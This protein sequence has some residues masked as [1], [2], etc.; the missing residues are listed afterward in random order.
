MMTWTISARSH[1]TMNTL[2]FHAVVAGISAAILSG[3]A[4]TPASSVHSLTGEEIPAVVSKPL[5]TGPFPA[6]VVL[7]DCAGAGPHGS[8]MGDRWTRE[9]VQQGYVVIQPDS[10]SS[11]GFEHG[12]CHIPVKDRKDLRDRTTRVKD[13]LGA[14]AYLRT[15][16]YV[17]GRHIGVMGG[18]HGGSATLGVIAAQDKLVGAGQ[19]FTAGIALYPGCEGGW[20]QGVGVKRTPR[21][22]PGPHVYSHAG[23]FNPGAPLLILAGEQ[24]DWTPAGFCRELT[25]ASK[26]ASF[27]IRLKVYPEA[28]HSFD[29]PRP[30]AYRRQRVNPYA[31]DGWGA[32]T[33]GNAEARA[34][35]EI[36]V[37]DFFAATLRP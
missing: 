31:E 29:S 20:G 24:D 3:C 9:L 12:V 6:V 33:G 8:G 35:A 30:I 23:P 5:G 13:A 36:Q 11:R 2:A 22:G 14:L 7:H 4:A 10:F 28:H 26:N 19:G 37:R 25:E 34:N 18:S 1:S 32:T 17:D 27:P 21:K 15:L 16:P